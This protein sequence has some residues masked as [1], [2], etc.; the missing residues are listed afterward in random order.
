LCHIIRNGAFAAQAGHPSFDKNVTEVRPL[1]STQFPGLLRYYGPL[2]LPAADDSQVMDSLMSLPFM[3]AAPGLPGSSTDLSARA[4]PNHPG[5]LGR[6]SRSLLP[7]RWQ[8]S[9]N[10][11][12]W[13]PPY[14]CNEA[15]SGSLALGL[16]PSLSRKDHFLSPL[17]SQSRDRPAPR[18][19]LPCT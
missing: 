8:A 4:L 3:G 7:C 2:R 18:V 10:L 6:C 17:E 16:A 19:R 13:P 9:P 14:K 11:G 1:G 12:G 15:E 5:R